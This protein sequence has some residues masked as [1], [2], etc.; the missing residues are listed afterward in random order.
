MRSS[1]FFTLYF[2]FLCTS[3]SQ[4]DAWRFLPG[5]CFFRSSL[6][7]ELGTKI[8]QSRD[9]EV[10]TLHYDAPPP[11]S[12]VHGFST[13]EIDGMS[14][15]QKDNLVLLYKKLRRSTPPI[16]EI[17]ESDSGESRR[18]L[19]G[20]ALMVYNK[21]FDWQISRIGLRDNEDWADDGRSF[22]VLRPYVNY[23]YI[24]TLTTSTVIEDWH[25]SKQVPPLNA[26]LPIVSGKSRQD[27]QFAPVKI[28]SDETQLIIV[29]SDQFEDVRARNRDARSFYIIHGTNVNKVSNFDG[30]WES[31]EFTL[32]K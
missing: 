29:E 6:T 15:R 18:E 26:K 19:N 3:T 10:I 17:T 20:M 28:K 2:V 14:R 24:E 32:D 25:G 5:D 7:H 16:F 22:G 1:L 30:H 31:S 23:P 4:A 21:S 12:Y 8:G 13:L 9:D 11:A 27:L